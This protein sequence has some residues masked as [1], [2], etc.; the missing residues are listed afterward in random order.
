M[1]SCAQHHHHLALEEEI[2]NAA[3]G[4]RPCITEAHIMPR[5]THQCV[6]HSIA[7]D[8]PEE[9]SWGIPVADTRNVAR[10]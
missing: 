9:S 8:T 1:N 6:V 2:N 10:R 7:S 4:Q 5:D 3:Q